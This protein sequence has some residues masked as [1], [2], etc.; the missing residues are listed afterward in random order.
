[1]NCRVV[2]VRTEIA[3]NLGAAARVMA[4]LGFRDLVLV[5]PA[6]NPRDLQAR[7]LATHGEHLLESCRVTATLAE[8]VADCV[9]VAATSARIG[10]LFRRQTV[11]APEEVLPLVAEVLEPGPAALV[12]GPESSGLRNDEVARCQY[13]VHIATEPECQ[14]LN[15]AQCV[16]ICLYELRRCYR[17][18][19]PTVPREAP[20]PF[21]YQQRAFEQLEEELKRIGYLRGEKAESLMHALRHL[22]GRAGPSR[23][24]V[25]LLFGL[26]RQIRWFADHGTADGPAHG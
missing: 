1:V 23:M 19:R 17:Q 9:L 5:E 20:A 7:A 12:F 16:A 15:L 8:A 25:D 11:G 4:N 26:A 6:A 2:L 22:L 10:G 24:E 18:R 21:A 13:L 3:A 14:A